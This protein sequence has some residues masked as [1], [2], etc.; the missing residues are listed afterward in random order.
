MKA[1]RL[2]FPYLRPYKKKLIL[3]LVFITLFNVLIT[4]VPFV[5]SGIIDKLRKSPPDT[6]NILLDLTILLGLTAIAG[7]FLFLTRRTIIVSSRLIEYDIRND[8]L[9]AIQKQETAFFQEYPTGALMAL[10]TNDVS[11]VR[12]FL[13]PAIMY[14]ANTLTS[15]TFVFSAMFSLHWGLA[16]SALIPLPFMAYVTY[17]VG[18]KVHAA[19]KSVQ[20]TYGELTVRS[21]ESMSGI[22]VVRAYST[23]KYEQKEFELVSKQYAQKN[24]ALSRIQS[25]SMPAMMALIGLSNVI[26]LGYGGYL[27]IHGGLTEGILVQFLLYVNRLI[28]PVAAIGW[29]TNLV[30]RA[31]ASAIRL[32]SVI[33]REP[34][35]YP[36][37]LQSSESL[38]PSIEFK[39]VSFSYPGSIPV[40]YN[41][42]FV[43]QEGKSL[44]IVGTTGSGKSSLVSLIPR[45]YDVTEGQILI[46]G[47]SLQELPLS[48]LRNAISFV[49]QE[50]FLFSMSIREN[51]AFSVYNCSEEDIVSA[52]KSAQLHDDVMAFDKKYDTIV[53]ERGITLS[54]G[55]KQRTALA[56][57][58]VRQPQ[59][60]ILDDSF[61][62]VDTVTESKILQSMKEVM[63]NRTTII[64]AHRLTSVKNCD[65][66]IVLDEGRI[67]EHGSHEALI[68]MNGLYA[69]MFERQK[70]EEELQI[71]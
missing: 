43:L 6:E 23:E 61:S 46:G 70:L 55:Q 47:K 64:I 3:G 65:E 34:V 49:N 31:A 41:I 24:I 51:I 17:R 21:Q 58:I 45:L 7:T 2:L 62:A 28:W 52:S 4:T 71:G 5:V 66:I 22:R 35:Y 8:L 56:R 29:V 42:S 13:G 63:K 38:T 44:G 30:Q 11:S 68:S 9:A 26:V 53:G 10:C 16:L 19:F 50:P 14:S 60:L 1:L 27:V 20:E 12:E 57:A 40:L 25:L 69:D 18:Q 48:Q 36:D 59:I 32:R 33:Y 37:F 15:F 67:I 39:N 54:G